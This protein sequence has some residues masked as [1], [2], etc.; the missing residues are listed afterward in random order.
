[1]LGSNIDRSDSLVS[2]ACWLHLVMGR[3]RA[4]VQVR[5]QRGAAAWSPA[6]LGHYNLV[7]GDDCQL[8][9]SFQ[10]IQ[11]AATPGTERPH[12]RRQLP[13]PAT[14][15]RPAAAQPAQPERPAHVVIPSQTTSS[16]QC[17]P[18][19]P[20]SHLVP[21]DLTSEFNKV[22]GG[23]ASERSFSSPADAAATT[24]AVGTLADRLFAPPAEAVATTPAARA[25][26]ASSPLS[27][28]A[29]LALA[30]QLMQ[31]S[32]MTAAAKKRRCGGSWGA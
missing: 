4:G 12:A 15:K 11:G 32:V 16:L 9:G 7:H 31:F 26:A 19:S 28:L 14:I 2:S 22:V 3:R 18:A 27:P 29:T 6:W 10:Q 24:P 23:G 13:K 17:M 30:T 1:M 21:R 8:Q 25:S 5:Q 20:P